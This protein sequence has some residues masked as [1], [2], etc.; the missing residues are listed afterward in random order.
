MPHSGKP[1]PVFMLKDRLRTSV[2]NIS[3]KQSV[4]ISKNQS[5]VIIMPDSVPA[6]L[7]SSSYI[8]YIGYNL[9]RRYIDYL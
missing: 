9:D 3:M 5:H 1:G 6:F 7:H 4:I 8:I 2:T